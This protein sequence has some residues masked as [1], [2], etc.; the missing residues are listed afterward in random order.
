[1][2]ELL[3]LTGKQLSAGEKLVLVTVTATSGAVPRGAGARMLVGRQGLLAGTIGG[4]A[5]EHRA[6][7]LATALLEEGR[8]V[9]HRFALNRRDVEDLGM[10]CGGDVEVFFSLL[11]PQRG[12]LDLL[13]R[14]E[15]AYQKGRALW[16]I[17]HLDEGF[18]LSC[19]TRE[20]GLWGRE[21]PGRLLEELP[22]RACHVHMEGEGD[23]CIEQINSP[24]RVWIFGAGHVARELEPMLS[25]VGFRCVVLDDREEFAC[26]DCFPTAE[27]VRLT[28]FSRPEL[29]DE[30]G[31]QDYVCVMTRGHASDTIIQAAVLPKRPAYVGVIGS[32]KKAAAVR[33][34]L[35]ADYGLTDELLDQVTTPIGL[36][37]FAETPAEI[38]VSITAQLIACRAQRR[39]REKK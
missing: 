8:S 20:E 6:I 15:E 5:V 7:Q 2:R 39:N 30:I 38:A 1:M 37:I 17:T 31:R 23:F 36:S 22:E 24:G 11:T 14:A 13:A 4:G 10:I 21:C 28:D 9:S 26:R 18:P 16:L 34:K 33:E 25:H 27:E 35:R 29:A 12:L 19:Y 32:R 3:D